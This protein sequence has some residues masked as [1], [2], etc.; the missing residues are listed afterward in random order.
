MCAVCQCLVGQASISGMIE[1][2]KKEKA[3][4]GVAGPK[5][6]ICIHRPEHLSYTAMAVITAQPLEWYAR[7]QRNRNILHLSPCILRA[8][9][10]PGVEPCY[11]AW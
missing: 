8:R 1:R 9:A 6:I 11:T 10:T 2:S 3:I 5:A 4:K 7:M